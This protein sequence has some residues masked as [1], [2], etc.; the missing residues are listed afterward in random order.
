MKLSK[1]DN[2]SPFNAFAVSSGSLRVTDPCYDMQTWCAGTL[3]N[4][5]NGIW[6]AHVGYHK[7]GLDA[8]MA[9][10]W[11]AGEKERIDAFVAKHDKDGL[12]GFGQYEYERLAEKRKAFEERLG[13][14]AY[15]HIRHENAQSHFDHEAEFDSTWVDSDIDVG[16]DSGQAGFF[17]YA[18]FDQVCG[19][20][21]VKEKFYD[22]VCDLTLETDGNWGVHPV[23]CVSSTGYGD[24]SYTCLVRRDEEGRAIEAI[25]V[26]MPEY[27]DEEDEG[28]DD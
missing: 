15:L 8:E 22:E 23:G 27:E 17:D 9:E 1:I 26:Y 13:R 18:L 3:D 24:G 12:S 16:V 14:V 19:S 25:I 28:S 4:V 2:I 6:Q 7:D 20:E 5:K 11:L 10:K 21:P